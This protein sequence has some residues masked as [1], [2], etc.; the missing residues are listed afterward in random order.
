MT[1]NPYFNNYGFA[2]EQSLLEDLGVE[3]IQQYG[4]N[5]IYI[6]RKHVNIDPLF[7]EDP[8]SQFTETRTI[9]MYMKSFM[10]YGQQSDMMMKFGLF[11]ADVLML[12]VMRKRFNQELPEY[13]R[14]LEGDLI[15]IPMTKAL[16]EIKYV[17][18]EDNFYQ[19]GTLQ[20]FDIKCERFVYS[21]ETFNTG[22]ADLD[23][24]EDRFSFAIVRE[25]ELEDEDGNVF[26]SESGDS[27]LSEAYAIDTKEGFFD[28]EGFVLEDE[29]GVPMA[30]EPVRKV[31]LTVQNE[32]FSTK[33]NDILDFDEATPFGKM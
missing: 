12:S 4:L 27:I 30:S 15:Y 16:F 22:I 24:I 28:E 10:G 11:S 14:P 6:K 29:G 19:Q 9:E 26:L 20:Y 23:R 13:V 31:P 3:M 8:L 18:H 21:N 5:V 17:E 32:Y 1:L 2:N 25:F 7:L 33:I